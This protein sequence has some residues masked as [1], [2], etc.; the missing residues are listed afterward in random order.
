[1]RE[2]NIKVKPCVRDTCFMTGE[3][4]DVNAVIRIDG[5][6]TNASLTKLIDILTA[7]QRP[8]KDPLDDL[9]THADHLDDEDV[10][11]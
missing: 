7:L 2:M 10:P 1:M 6:L 4:A 11:F 9:R 8:R 3:K 5:S